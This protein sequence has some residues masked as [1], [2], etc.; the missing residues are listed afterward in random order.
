MIDR[1]KFCKLLGGG[2]V[3]LGTRLTGSPY[4]AADAT[5]GEPS[6]KVG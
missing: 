1:R 4:Y 2:I 3:V 6:V 5:A